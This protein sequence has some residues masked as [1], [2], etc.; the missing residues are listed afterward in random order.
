MFNGAMEAIFWEDGHL[1]ADLENGIYPMAQQDTKDFLVGFVK[2]TPGNHFVVKAGDAQK[3][4]SLKIVHAGARPEGYEVMKKQGGIVLGI[5]G[6]NSPW[7][8]GIFYEGVMTQ[9]Y[10]SDEA[11]A[12]IMANIV[13]AGYSVKQDLPM[14]II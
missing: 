5:G 4:G 8:A 10:S 13:E 7:G 11:D 6:D 12:A 2:G 9:G 14:L 3:D 1:G